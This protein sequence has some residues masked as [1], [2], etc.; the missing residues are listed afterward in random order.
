MGHRQLSASEG[1]ERA[2]DITAVPCDSL[3][4]LPA[5]RTTSASPQSTNVK[6]PRQT[7]STASSRGLCVRVPNPPSPACPGDAL[8]AVQPDRGISHPP[9]PDICRTLAARL[10]HEQSF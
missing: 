2:W 10:E 5:P 3:L 8:P 1:E 4:A 9:A 6:A 7:C